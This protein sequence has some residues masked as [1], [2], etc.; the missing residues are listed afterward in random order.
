MQVTH[1]SALLE[2]QARHAFLDTQDPEC[3]A[4]GKPNYDLTCMME[5]LARC[6]DTKYNSIVQMVSARRCRAPSFAFA[7]PS[8]CEHNRPLQNNA[9]SALISRASPCRVL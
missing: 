1:K 7:E 9:T 4:V 8:H 2:L 6:G 3:L 5:A